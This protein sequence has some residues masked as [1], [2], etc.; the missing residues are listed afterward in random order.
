M[1][2]AEHTYMKGHKSKYQAIHN[3]QINVQRGLTD[4]NA[5]NLIS[6]IRDISYRL[7]NTIHLLKRTN[8]FKHLEALFTFQK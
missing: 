4:P 7:A 3:M 5:G 2:K 1:W 6:K 8:Y